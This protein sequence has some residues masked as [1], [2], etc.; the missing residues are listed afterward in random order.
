MG[1]PMS[2]PPWIKPSAL[3]CCESHC[4]TIKWSDLVLTQNGS[5]NFFLTELHHGLDAANLETTATLKPDGSFDLH[6]PHKGAAK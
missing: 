5:G 6:T 3:K 2:R 1:D 4:F